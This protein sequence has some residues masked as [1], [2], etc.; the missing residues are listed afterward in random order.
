MIVGSGFI[1]IGWLMVQL[2]LP[3][4]TVTANTGDPTVPIVGVIVG[5][6]PAKETPS[7]VQL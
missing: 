5:V 6:F 1:T 2:P 4:V 3:L 7:I